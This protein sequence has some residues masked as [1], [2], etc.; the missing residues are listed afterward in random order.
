[1]KAQNEQ[2]TKLNFKLPV[3]SE[4][5]D[6]GL[7]LEQV[8]RFINSYL[9]GFPEMQV[10]TSMI[11]NYAKQKLI[12]RVNRKTYSRRQIAC[13][14]FIV[15]AKTVLSIDHIKKALQK[16]EAEKLEIEEMYSIFADSLEKVV[17]LLFSGQE[18]SLTDPRMEEREK[19]L[20]RISLVIGHKMYLEHYF[21]VRMNPQ[22]TSPA[23]RAIL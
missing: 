13:L 23:T 3:Y 19:L 16:L 17:K 9:T 15:C 6:I 14:L 2:N 11:S 22:K 10:T 1:M 20:R 18:V 8:A 4:I 21:Y 12:D 5:P 7:Y